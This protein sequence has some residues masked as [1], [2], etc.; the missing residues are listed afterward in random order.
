MW[1]S[2]LNLSMNYAEKEIVNMIRIYTSSEKLD[3]D[4]SHSLNRRPGRSSMNRRTHT[5]R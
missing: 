1:M 2:S 4:G 3:V 5:A